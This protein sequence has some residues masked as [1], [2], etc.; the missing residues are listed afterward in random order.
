MF[1]LF[2]RLIKG[3]IK[4]NMKFNRIKLLVL[5][6]VFIDIV[7]LGVV[8][9]ILPFYVERFSGSPLT[10]TA[11]FAVFALCSFVSSPWI[12]ALS[13]RFGRRPGAV[14]HGRAVCLARLRS[15]FLSAVFLFGAFLVLYR[16]RRRLACELSPDMPVISEV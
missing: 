4:I 12:G 6:T 15:V 16:A 8:I 14:R 3:R 10:V 1:R 5:F 7:G 2:F 11:L 13:D 9:P